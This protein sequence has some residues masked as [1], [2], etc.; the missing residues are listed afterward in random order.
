MKLRLLSRLRLLRILQ[1]NGLNSRFI[2]RKP[3]PTDECVCMNCGTHFTGF[4]CP[5]CGQSAKTRRLSLLNTIEDSVSLVT[6]L[7]NGILRSCTELYWR[8]GHMMRDYILGHRK[9]YMK[10]M[11]LLFCLGT[12][13]YFFILIFAKEALPSGGL[14]DESQITL[15]G[16]EQYL[17]LIRSAQDLFK[18]W[19]SNPAMVHFSLILPMVP[20]AWLC[21]RKIHIGH[22]LNLMEHFNIQVMMASQM[23]IMTFFM[24][25]YNLIFAGDVGYNNLQFLPIFLLFVWDYKQL[26]QIHW[27][28]S[29]RR[30]LF[31]FILTFV[32]SLL[33]IAL[34]SLGVAIFFN[35]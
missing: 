21:Y 19:Y 14:I 20:S 35:R 12:L 28:Q 31:C 22:A 1:V 9:G 34:V 6:N 3:Y 26:Y 10:P 16:A 29:V 24:S 8:P 7:D 13:Y 5:R 25:I 15:E 11:S 27:K 33:V 18:A 32:L 2:T 17:P 30:T 23:L 4:F